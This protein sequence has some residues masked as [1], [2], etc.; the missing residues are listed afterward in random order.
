MPSILYF[1]AD[2]ITASTTNLTNCTR[3]Y[4]FESYFSSHVI[5]SYS[6]AF[7]WE[8]IRSNAKEAKRHVLT[9]SY[10]GAR[11]E[12]EF[13]QSIRQALHIKHRSE[14]SWRKE[15][16]L[17]R[18][19]NSGYDW[20]K[21]GKSKSNCSYCAKFLNNLGSTLLT[22]EGYM[23]SCSTSGLRVEFRIS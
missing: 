23:H 21:R 4:K 19:I 18:I 13:M 8:G 22:A 10:D 3:S 1:M 15:K 7:K 9:D 17:F 6:R 2:F 20:Q 14:K 12:N 5:H 11:R 16:Y